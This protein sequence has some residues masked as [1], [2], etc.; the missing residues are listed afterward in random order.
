MTAKAQEESGLDSID[1]LLIGSMVGAAFVLYSVLQGARK[2]VQDEIISE[3]RRLPKNETASKPV[4]LPDESVINAE[5]ELFS[6]SSEERASPKIY[7]KKRDQVLTK[8]ET[9]M[10]DRLTEAFPDYLIQYQIGLSQLVEVS[11]EV[12]FWDRRGQFSRIA[13]LIIDFVLVDKKH[14]VVACIELDDWTHSR[15]ERVDADKRKNEALE[16]AGYKL[17]RYTYVPTVEE[18]KN[19]VLKV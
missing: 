5:A 11:E 10:Y 19:D 3:I 16:S 18:L 9:K 15:P 17:L 14:N 4:M 12:K 8:F 7:K 1:L 13:R 2:R 6:K